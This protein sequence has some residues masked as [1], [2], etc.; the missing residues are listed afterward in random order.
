MRIG[1]GS[2]SVRKKES[3]PTNGPQI[4]TTMRVRCVRVRCHRTYCNCSP[5]CSDRV[6]RAMGGGVSKGD[7]GASDQTP[8]SSGPREPGLE[9]SAQVASDGWLVTISDGLSQ[10]LDI[11]DG[12]PFGVGTACKAFKKVVDTAKLLQHNKDQCKA[13][14][15]DTSILVK[16]MAELERRPEKHDYLEE[17]IGSLN[18]EAATK[19][20][21]P[22]E[23]KNELEVDA[24]EEQAAA[25][26]AATK[27][28]KHNL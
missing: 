20:R 22:E 13:I 10:L 23:L 1:S 11:A 24:W 6:K 9:S 25:L 14:L 12:A 8:S 2:L 26:E 7:A 5:G 16:M 15:T 28:R 18:Q 4:G 17:S 19:K 3:G 21:T 27:K